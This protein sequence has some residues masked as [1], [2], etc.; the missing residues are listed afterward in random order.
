MRILLPILFIAF[1]SSCTKITNT[2]LLK[3]EWEIKEAYMN[4]GSTNQMAQLFSDFNQSGKYL[5][6]FMDEGLMKSEY[7]IDAELLEETFGR[8]ELQ[9]HDLIYLKMDEFVDGEFQIE[10]IDQ[11]HFKL[12]SAYND[13]S[14][15]DIGY[16]SMELSLER[17]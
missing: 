8:W 11:E 7:Y 1:S 17:N 2:M 16:S 14:F 13:V 15:Y 6:Y 4:G 12:F 3:G 5:T 10:I 9:N